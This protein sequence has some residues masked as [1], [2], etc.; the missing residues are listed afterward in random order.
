MSPSFVIESKLTEKLFCDYHE[1]IE[2]QQVAIELREEDIDSFLLKKAIVYEPFKEQYDNIFENSA[3]IHL[4]SRSK[5]V[6]RY[7]EIGRLL[8]TKWKEELE[9]AHIF[10]LR[11]RINDLLSNDTVLAG[12]IISDFYGL[13][14][15]RDGRPFVWELVQEYVEGYKD[16]LGPVKAKSLEAIVRSHLLGLYFQALSTSVDASV[17]SFKD[18]GL[19]KLEHLVIDKS[20]SL[21][22]FDKILRI[23]KLN[24]IIHGLDGSQ[25][26]DTKSTIEYKCFKETYI[27]LLN[28]VGQIDKIYD[29][30]QSRLTEERRF[31]NQACAD[32]VAKY[33]S[34]RTDNLVKII[35]GIFTNPT[36]NIPQ[37]VYRHPSMSTIAESVPLMRFRDRIVEGYDILS[38][39]DY[40]SL[41]NEISKLEKR[42]VFV[43]NFHFNGP[44]N[45]SHS[46]VGE[47]A[48]VHNSFEKE[49]VVKLFEELNGAISGLEPSIKEE[50][51][52]KISE[53]RESVQSNETSRAMLLWNEVKEGVK[54]S[55]AATTI[56]MA[57]KTLLFG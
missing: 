41:E 9:S 27:K 40:R 44:T 35:E 1:L 37:Q 25:I 33:V 56:L 5:V 54:T 49:A 52:A 13:P 6:Y 51:A 48:T 3:S 20:F 8:E 18:V 39:V 43:A 29:V 53:L 19:L 34:N 4:L 21:D 32:I 31:F 2:E 23:L 14:E 55:A 45:I 57:I 42:G 38:H 7:E 50:A 11:S 46:A 26:L 30:L 28:A 15:K 10:S 12:L 47:N 22:M 36:E 24:K 16:M 17:G